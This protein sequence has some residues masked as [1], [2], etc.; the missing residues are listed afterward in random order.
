MVP[1][2]ST[3]P[4][5]LLRLL[6]NMA[7]GAIIMAMFTAFVWGCGATAILLSRVACVTGG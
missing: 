7:Y 1:E 5:R 6:E 2:I 3:S 4:V